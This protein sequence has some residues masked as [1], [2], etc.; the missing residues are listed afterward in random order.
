MGLGDR[1][2]PDS[3]RDD[4]IEE[5]R[6]ARLVV[7]VSLT[8]VVLLLLGSINAY[9]D[10]VA[11]AAQWP[12]LTAGLLLV[13]PFVLRATGRTSLVAN[14][15]V[16]GIAITIGIGNLARFAGGYPP[17]I[18]TAIGPMVAVLLCGWRVGIVWGGVS[19]LQVILLGAA[20]GGVLSLPPS[21]FPSAE[22]IQGTS[23]LRASGVLTVILTLALV[24][25]WRK[26]RSLKELAVTRD[27]AKR[28]DQAKSEFVASLSH[29]VRTPVSVIIGISDMLL[30][31]EL[32]EE[33]KDLV[34]TLQ[35]SGHNLLGLVNDILDLSKIEAGRLELESV[36]FD[37]LAVARD[38][39]R[40]L[41]PPADDKGIVFDVTVGRGIPRWVYGDPAR[42]R[43]VLLNLVGNA[44]KFTSHGG[45]DLRIHVEKERGE[46]VSISFVV[47]D[48]G[49]GIPADELPRLFERY[50]QIDASTARLSGGSGLGLPISQE[51]VARMKGRLRATSQ[52][53]LGSEF[54]FTLPMT[55]A[56]EP[57]EPK[58]NAA[59]SLREPDRR[60][61]PSPAR[62]T[63]A[64]A[65][66]S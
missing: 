19:I 38:V 21:W 46:E 47:S 43:Q 26:V 17:L 2:V 54:S 22:I 11:A 3:I 27:Q 10:G 64:S 55:L 8:G 29:E 28:A 31:T 20:H 36:S 56:E 37:V 23:R 65:P 48:T 14:L 49:V 57:P 50:A 33:Q 52:P 1:F 5:V 45:V 63:K 24:Y 66:T 25:D 58:S 40:Q 12:L 62:R 44:I 34:R 15:V 51:L 35:L 32:D 4:G 59:Q 13:L 61:S 42:L 30:D 7:G 16:A 18:A 60:S 53:G 6:R 39:R 41:S 9:V